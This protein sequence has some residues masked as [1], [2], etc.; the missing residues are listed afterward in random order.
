[1]LEYSQSTLFV[2]ISDGQQRDSVMH[3]HVAILPQTP[4]FPDHHMTL[5]RVPCVIN[6]MFLK[7]ISSI[8][9]FVSSFLPNSID[10]LIFFVRKQEE[11]KVLYKGFLLNSFFFFLKWFWIN[12][13][14]GIIVHSFHMSITQFL[15]FLIIRSILIYKFTKVISYGRK[16]L[17][18]SLYSDKLTKW[19]WRP[20]R[21]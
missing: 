16:Y 17:C 2:I 12:R 5:S 18:E 9:K 4:S 14:V 21:S 20:R 8:H 7:T 10:Q 6:V 13:K 15:L 3:K 11:S 1:M 19:N